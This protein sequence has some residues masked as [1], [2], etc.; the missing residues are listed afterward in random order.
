VGS[1]RS[2]E[3]AVVE[4]AGGCPRARVAVAGL[5][6]VVGVALEG[7][8]RRNIVVDSGRDRDRVYTCTHAYTVEGG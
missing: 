8:E 1:E 7:G 5:Q 4:G 3:V 6:E 2:Q